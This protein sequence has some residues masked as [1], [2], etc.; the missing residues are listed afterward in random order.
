MVTG[1]D[2]ADWGFHLL[3]DATI[4]YAATFIQGFPALHATLA[5]QREAAIRDQGK[6]KA[7][8]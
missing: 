3:N 6:E 7:E 2:A 1:R 8:T 5:H 4:L